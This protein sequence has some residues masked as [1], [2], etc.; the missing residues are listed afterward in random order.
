MATQTERDPGLPHEQDD[1]PSDLGENEDEGVPYDG[2]LVRLP[3]PGSE[4]GE[5]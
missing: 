5:E 2:G 4:P 3:A 1:Q